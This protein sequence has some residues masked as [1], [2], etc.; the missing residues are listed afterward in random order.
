MPPAGAQARV[1][2]KYWIHKEGGPSA[3][4][5]RRAAGA[6]PASAAPPAAEL[7]R[8]SLRAARMATATFALGAG[9][10]PDRLGP[11]QVALPDSAFYVD[12]AYWGP[13]P[14]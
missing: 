10:G 13:E 4:P 3:R 9:L 12:L 14:P 7:A 11:R 6:P 1:D 8:P 5:G 2:A